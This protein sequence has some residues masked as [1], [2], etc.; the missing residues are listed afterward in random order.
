ML[1]LYLCAITCLCGA[2][3]WAVDLTDLERKWLDAASPVIAYANAMQL[4]LDVI[5]QPE[6]EPQDVPIALGHE[7]GRC[8]LVLSLRGNP[9][10]EAIL[11]G[12]NPSQHSILIE[13]M[14]AHELGHCWRYVQGKWNNLP[15]GFNSI[16]DNSGSTSTADEQRRSKEEARREEGFADLV[17]LAWAEHHHPEN[18]Q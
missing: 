18:Y 16:H 11:A 3:A 4:P 2:N 10:A 14:A 7:A 6:T 1:K 15:A 5:V 12:I 13:T 9:G 8:K 17:G